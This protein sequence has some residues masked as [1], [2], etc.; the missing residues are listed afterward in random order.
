[1]VDRRTSPHWVRVQ[2]STTW[3]RSTLVC[4]SVLGMS[5]RIW[6]LW[7]L[8]SRLN[9]RSPVTAVTDDGHA[10]LEGEFCR[11]AMTSG[12]ICTGS[13]QHADELA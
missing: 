6:S 4:M 8:A 13:F 5:F 11:E 10:F 12:L 9:A 3:A 1:M 7:R 2:G